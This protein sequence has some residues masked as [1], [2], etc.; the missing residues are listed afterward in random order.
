M[1]GFKYIYGET[2]RKVEDRWFVME[3]RRYERKEYRG[4]RKRFKEKVGVKINVWGF[5]II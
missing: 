4:G 2:D 3:E 5:G 1:N